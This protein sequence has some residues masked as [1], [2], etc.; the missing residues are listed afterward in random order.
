[1]I[2]KLLTEH[3][4][5]FLSLRGGC[6]GS[7]KFTL[8]KM[9]HYWKSHA[10]AQMIFCDGSVDQYNC[11][12]DVLAQYTFTIDLEVERPLTIKQLS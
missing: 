6:R 11:V 10:L 3:H 2:V 8:V 12:L 7:S 9:P 4:L 1:M 5:E